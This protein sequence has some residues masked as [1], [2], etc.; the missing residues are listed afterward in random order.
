MGLYVPFQALRCILYLAKQL[1][2]PHIQRAIGSDEGY[3]TPFFFTCTARY[4]QVI[5]L[6]EVLPFCRSP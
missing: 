1:Q 2:R 5:V 6:F 3:C 4:S